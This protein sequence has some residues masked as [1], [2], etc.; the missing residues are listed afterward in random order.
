MDKQVTEN[1]RIKAVG[2]LSGGLDSTLAARLM[3]D[4]G[5]QVYAINFTSPFCTC[6]PK[7]ASCASVLNAIRQLGGIPLRRVYL[8]D[9]YLEVIRN[10]KYGYGSGINPCIDCRILKVKKAAQYMREIGGLFLFTGEVLGQRPMSQYRRALE[11]ID[12][13]AG[14]TGYILRPLSASHLKP[15]V[16]ELEGWVDREK[17]LGIS[18][19]PR[20]TQMKLAKDKGI[21]E[22]PCPAGGCLL[23]DKNFA[24]RIRD[25]FQ[26]VATPSMKDMALLKIGRHFRLNNGDKVIVARNEKECKVMK[27]LLRPED[28][29]LTPFGFSGPTVMLQGTDLEQAVRMLAKYTKMALKNDNLLLHDHMGQQVLVTIGEVCTPDKQWTPEMNTVIKREFGQGKTCGPDHK[30]GLCSGEKGLGTLATH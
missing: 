8:G 30:K 22:F 11:I 1:R 12:R 16:P 28:H 14:M 23:T 29:M 18:G 17:R 15:T 2:L 4:Q 5:I 3:L 7:T 26:H 19:R 21:Y 13:E 25:Y 20:K 6:T 9:E 24:E 10:P 27:E